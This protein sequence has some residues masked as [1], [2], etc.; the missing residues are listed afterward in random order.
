MTTLSTLVV[1][2]V[3]GNPGGPAISGSVEASAGY[4]DNVD[5][6]FDQASGGLG[7][8]SPSPET[9]L[10][11]SLSIA[12]PLGPVHLLVAPELLA[13]AFE[14]LGARDYLWGDLPLLTH[15]RASQVVAVELAD[16][17]TGQWI[18]GLPIYDFLRNG[19]EAA[20]ELG[21]GRWRLRTDYDVRIKRYPAL[22]LWNFTAH[23]VGVAITYDTAPHW[24]VTGGVAGQLNSGSPLFPAGAP[25]TGEQLL[26]FGRLRALLP[27]EIL[28]QL[29][30]LLR[31]A[32]QG[33]FDG[34]DQE[35]IVGG[36]GAI[37]EDADELS[38]GGFVKHQID[39]QLDVPL[40]HRWDLDAFA[41]FASKAF[42]NVLVGPSGI[43]RV[44]D[45]GLGSLSAAY[46]LDAR[47]T[48][49]LRL[50]I[51][52]NASTEAERAYLNREGTLSLD[53]GW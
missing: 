40:G 22:P 28:L 30:Y 5:L 4:N 50:L 39:L 51:A 43:P 15:W 44:D 19:G 35:P 45:L 12:A 34:A 14:A 11:A 29:H 13:R 18:P 16:D 37:E 21:R 1:L 24:L 36:G 41:L 53:V 9:D 33:E 42:E 49:R 48:I 52:R 6:L 27:H 47:W 10:D 25:T 31:L 26:P 7:A 2:V 46:Q 8:F 23:Q 32:Y 38:E 17:L 20:I 3:L